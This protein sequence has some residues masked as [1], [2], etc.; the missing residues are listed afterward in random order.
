[1]K[2]VVALLATFAI[3][4]CISRKQLAPFSGAVAGGG[5]GALVG[6][7]VGGAVG[8]GVGYASGALYDWSKE[9]NVG[10]VSNAEMVA[11]LHDKLDGHATGTHTLLDDIKRFFMLGAI[12]L[13]VYLSIPIFINTRQIC[14]RTG[15]QINKKE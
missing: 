6:G 3:T 12:G 7:P 14:K 10:G 1:M 15:N 13:A 2:I 4:G 8:S 5:V 11:I 9:E